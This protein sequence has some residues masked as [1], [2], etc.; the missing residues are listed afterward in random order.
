MHQG[1]L[2][3]FFNTLA[4]RLD[5]LMGCKSTQPDNQ[6]K[7]P[8]LLGYV[9]LFRLQVHIKP[10]ARE[11][12]IPLYFFIK[13]KNIYSDCY[14]IFALAITCR[15]VTLF[16]LF[17]FITDRNNTVISFPAQLCSLNYQSQPASKLMTS[18][19]IQKLFFRLFGMYI[20]IL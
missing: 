11:N 15:C 6:G 13:S 18:F 8:W 19:F 4:A 17:F 7:T 1:I 5:G 9:D 10:V 14:F 3:S 2:L 12:V 20:C 16:S